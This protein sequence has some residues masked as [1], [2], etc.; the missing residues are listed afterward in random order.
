MS[1]E[2]WVGVAGAAIGILGTLG[3]T[4]LA[5]YLAGRK[6][7]RID[8]NRKV[9]LKRALKEVGGQGWVHINILAQLVGADIDTTRA[10]LIEIEA[11]GSMKPTRE[12]WSLIDRNPLPTQSDEN[13]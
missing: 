4:F 7:S 3:A 6:Q 8:R 1:S 11:R 10:L 13:V 5:D 2:T 12:S 9:L